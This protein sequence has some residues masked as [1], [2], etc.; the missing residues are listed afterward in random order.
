MCDTPLTWHTTNTRYQSNDDTTHIYI[1]AECPF[2]GFEY[3]ND[4]NT[5]D[6]Q[7][8]LSNRNNKK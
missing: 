5:H 8:F 6:L 2:I 3:L 4:N 1:C 7:N